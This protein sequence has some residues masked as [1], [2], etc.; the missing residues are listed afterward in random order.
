MS[1]TPDTP[2]VAVPATAIPAP[3]TAADDIPVVVGPATPAAVDL[4]RCGHEQ[5]AHEHYRPGTDC[6]ICG[7]ACRAFHA[8]TGRA[9]GRTAGRRA[10][11]TSRL[12]RR[13]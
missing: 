8:R 13:S 2:A 9:A 6:G 3:R 12:F 4:C 11:L 1:V 5:D 10:R 7:A